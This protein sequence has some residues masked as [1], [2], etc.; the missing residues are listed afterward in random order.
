MVETQVTKTSSSVGVAGISR[1]ERLSGA[2]FTGRRSALLTSTDPRTAADRSTVAP[3]PRLSVQTTQTRAAEQHRKRRVNGTIKR[4]LALRGEAATIFSIVACAALV[5]VLGIVYVAAY[6]TVA[7]Q[8]RQLHTLQ[9]QMAGAQAQHELLV[10]EF[11]R[12][13]SSSRIGLAAQGQ[14][15]VLNGPTKYVP[16]TTTNPA[17]LATSQVAMAR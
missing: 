17:A 15:M 13:S 2:A 10:Q 14:G 12:L 9:L 4:R 8:G 16:L 11:A 5:C 6:A 3:A 1:R 7:L